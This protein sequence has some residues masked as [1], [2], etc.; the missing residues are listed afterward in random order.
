MHM[1]VN[2]H[3]LDDCPQLPR[4]GAKRMPPHAGVVLRIDQQE[5]QE[6]LKQT[7]GLIGMVKHS[8]LFSSWGVLIMVKKVSLAAF[9]II[10]IFALL[11]NEEILFSRGSTLHLL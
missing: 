9:L 7:K 2:E 11:G 4:A 8:I 6:R 1:T 3:C 5:G 10:F